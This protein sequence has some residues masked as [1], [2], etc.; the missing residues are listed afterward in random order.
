L[1]KKMLDIMLDDGYW[2]LDAGY[3]MRDGNEGRLNTEP[4]VG[5][6][7]R[8]TQHR[9]LKKK[10]QAGCWMDTGRMMPAAYSLQPT[11]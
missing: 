4:A 7:A 1:K 9:I 10:I 11:A 8:N 3:W 2:I 5:R 6:Q